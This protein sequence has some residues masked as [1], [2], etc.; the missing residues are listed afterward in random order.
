MIGK[1]W[2]CAASSGLETGFDWDA[3]VAITDE[4]RRTPRYGVLLVAECDTDAMGT[5]GVRRNMMEIDGI[6]LDT[7]LRTLESKGTS[8]LCCRHLAPEYSDSGLD[9]SR[10]EH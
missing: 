5:G 7:E 2:N 10:L 4:I 1:V 9:W 3:F 8:S 6:R